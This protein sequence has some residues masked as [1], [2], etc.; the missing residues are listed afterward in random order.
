MAHSAQNGGAMNGQALDD[1]ELDPVL[2][3][4]RRKV[5]FWV[6]KNVLLISIAFLMVFNA[7]QGLSRLQVGFVLFILSCL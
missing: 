5:R 4:P 1:L 6:Y 7:F 3:I 2:K